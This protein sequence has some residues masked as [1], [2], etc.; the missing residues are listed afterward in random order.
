MEIKN[1][2]TIKFEERGDGGQGMMIVRQCD[3]QVSFCISLEDNGDIEALIDKEVAERLIKALSEAI[4][5]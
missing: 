3:S 2:D 4:G 5:R 1:I